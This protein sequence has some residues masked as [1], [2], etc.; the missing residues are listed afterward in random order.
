MAE[1][2]QRIDRLSHLLATLKPERKTRVADIGA[3]PVHVPAY[4]FL[5]DQGGCEVIGFEPDPRAFKELQEQKNGSNETYLPFAVGDDAEHTLHVC[6]QSGFTSLLKP[7]KAFTDY[8]G[9]F[10]RGMKV[11]QEIPLRTHRLDDIADLPEC[12]LLKIDIQGG[13]AEVFRNGPIFMANLAAVITEV[14]FIPLYENQPLLDEQMRILRDADL[15]LSKFLAF[16]R[17]RLKGNL[18][19]RLAANNEHRN[20]L[21]DADAVFHRQV[22]PTSKIA[23]EKLKHLAILADSVFDSCDVT[24]RC[25]DV[26]I[27]RGEVVLAE[28]EEYVER[29]EAR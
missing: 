16:K 13:E 26:L 25:L 4:Q 1:L 21:V 18:Q 8:T 3:N 23:S 27:D 11:M 29:L 5:L 28:A 19:T 22:S 17:V 14:A 12:D 20:Q 15:H 24:L 2:S 7:S 9:H 10:R 6:N